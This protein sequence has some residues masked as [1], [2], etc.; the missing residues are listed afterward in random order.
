MEASGFML[1][2]KTALMV[3]ENAGK[4]EAILHEARYSQFYC[5]QEVKRQNN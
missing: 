1:D 3:E 4:G 5:R 2:L